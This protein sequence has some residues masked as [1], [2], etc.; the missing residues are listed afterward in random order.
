MASATALRAASILAWTSGGIG[1]KG[2]STALAASFLDS[3][4]LSGSALVA[5]VLAVS[6]AGASAL[7]GWESFLV[8]P[9]ANNE[10]TRVNPIARTRQNETASVTERRTT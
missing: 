7:G 8:S 6:F 9:C 1:G 10:S 5:S 2:G 3:S 4:F